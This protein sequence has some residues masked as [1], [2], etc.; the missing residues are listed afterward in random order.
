[1]EK[2]LWSSSMTQEMVDEAGLDPEDVE[3]IIRELD[4]AVADICMAHGIS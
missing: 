3:S 1:M 2:I 4:D